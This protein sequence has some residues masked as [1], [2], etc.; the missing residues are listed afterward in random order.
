MGAAAEI[1]GGEEYGRFKGRTPGIYLTHEDPVDR[2]SRLTIV[3]IAGTEPA[4]G[5]S[6]EAEGCRGAGHLGFRVS[7]TSGNRIG[8]V[9]PSA[10]VTNGWIR[11]FNACCG[12]HIGHVER[13]DDNVGA[14]RGGGTSHRD[15]HAVTAAC[16]A[17]GRKYDL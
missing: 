4:H 1:G 13:I 16:E 17:R 6:S 14:A 7:P 15:H 8:S 10:G 11:I 3:G 5:G 12:A 9:N 2:D